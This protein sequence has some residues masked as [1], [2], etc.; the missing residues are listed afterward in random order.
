MLCRLKAKS[1]R[2]AFKKPMGQTIGLQRLKSFEIEER[3]HHPHAGGIA[4]SD[5]HDVRMKGLAD[6]RV[7]RDRLDEGLA[8][9]RGR[10]VAM[11]EPRGDTVRDRTFK[12]I[13]VEDANREK[14]PSSGS[15]RAASSASCRMRANSG[16]AP[17]IPTTRAVKPCAMTK[18][19]SSA[20]AAYHNIKRRRRPPPVGCKMPLN[21]RLG[22]AG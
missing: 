14:K 20:E 15:R 1:R 16:S 18:L 12:R 17:A 9:Q 19:P 11:I 3:L 8:D 13:V 6:R 22:A 5:R 4:I 7:A 2:P 21:A 10:Q